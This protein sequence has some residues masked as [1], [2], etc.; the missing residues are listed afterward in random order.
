MRVRAHTHT[1]RNYSGNN[2]TNT[3]QER[4]KIPGEWSSCN[5]NIENHAAIKLST[6]GKG[7]KEDFPDGISQRLNSRP[8]RRF[9]DTL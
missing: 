3:L 7:G 8:E 1:K 5:N 4:R 9:L 2:H 6:E